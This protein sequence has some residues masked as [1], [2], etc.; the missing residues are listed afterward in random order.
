MPAGIN[1][2]LGFEVTQITVYCFQGTREHRGAK[3]LGTSE[4]QYYPLRQPKASNFFSKYYFFLLS[5]KSS[6]CLI[7]FG[8]GHLYVSIS[9]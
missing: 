7:H 2:D 8:N 3:R 9:R 6:S 4:T 5:P 1:A